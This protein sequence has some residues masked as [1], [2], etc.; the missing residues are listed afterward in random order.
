MDDLQEPT[1]EITQ[2][3][4]QSGQSEEFS[5]DPSRAW[6]NDLPEDLRTAKTF[7]KFTAGDDTEF[8]KVPSEVLKSH[9][10]LE[11]MLSDRNKLPETPEDQKEFY[12]KLGWEP[13]FEKFSE[14]IKRA[15]MP[16]GVE[17]DTSEEEF[18]LQ[19][20]HE[21]HIP[22]KTA[23]AIYDDIIKARLGAVTDG[24]AA[25]DAY[26]SEVEESFKAKY[27]G[28]L[29]VMKNRAKVAM[30]DMGDEN[31]INLLETAEVDGRKLGDHPAMFEFMAK[32]G[33]S[34]LGLADE[35]GKST[36]TEDMASIEEQITELMAKP[37]YMDE[38]HVNHK[39]IVQRVNKLF[40][41]Q[42]G[43]I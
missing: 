9:M 29:D 25:K 14:G 36:N 35:R 27:Q 34:K 21:H 43:E 28:D 6:L 23:Q 40:Q 13:E 37:E 7:S 20:A 41:R 5:E 4:D 42:A 19:K 18:L 3:A 26:L 38:S 31:L 32:L 2:Q 30:T 17:Y 11:S 16:E 1:E 33:K 8:V 15:E 39:N 10:S 12:Q 24:G 22:V